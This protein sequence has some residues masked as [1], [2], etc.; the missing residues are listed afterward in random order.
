M[1][2][3]A[4]VLEAVPLGADRVGVRILDPADDADGVGLHLDG[5]ALALG[6]DELAVD[7]E[8]AAGVETLDLR[9]VVGQVIGRDDLDG[10]LAGA[11]VEIDK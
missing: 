6:L 9:L 7:F 2:D 11:V 8:G 4:E 3:L 10:V 1:R 5:L